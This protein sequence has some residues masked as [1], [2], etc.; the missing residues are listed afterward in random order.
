MNTVETLT[1]RELGLIELALSESIEKL[2]EYAY[3][4]DKHHPRRKAFKEFAVESEICK[5]KVE[6]IRLKKMRGE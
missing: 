1:I 5:L 4:Y 3:S 6:L 2:N